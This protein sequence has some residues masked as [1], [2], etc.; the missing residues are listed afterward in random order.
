[1]KKEEKNIKKENLSLINFIKRQ[2]LIK[3]TVVLLNFSKP[4]YSH[5]ILSLVLC[6]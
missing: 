5:H 4:I 1:M 2:Y 6:H 3:C